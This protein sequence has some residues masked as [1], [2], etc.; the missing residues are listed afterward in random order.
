MRKFSKIFAVLLVACILVSAMLVAASAAI[1]TAAQMP[2]GATGTIKTATYKA[3]VGDCGNGRQGKKYECFTVNVNTNHLTS[4]A[5]NG[6]SH[7]GK[8]C[9][10]SGLLFSIAGGTSADGGTVFSANDIKNFNFKYLTIDF[11]IWSDKYIDANGGLTDDDTGKIAYAPQLKLSCYGNSP[12][13]K[14]NFSYAYFV[15]DGTYWYLSIDDSYDSSDVR[16]S[17]TVNVKNH[18]TVIDDGKNSYVF[19]DGEYVGTNNFTASGATTF[20]TGINVGGGDRSAAKNFSIATSYVT[21]NSYSK[22]YGS[23]TKFGIDD[24]FGKAD[25][26]MNLHT[27]EDAWYGDVEKYP[28]SNTATATVTYKDSNGEEIISGEYN[29]SKVL[30]KEISSDLDNGWYSSSKS[31]KIVGADAAATAGDIVAGGSYTLVPFENGYEADVKNFKFNVTLLDEFKYNVYI[32]KPNIDGLTVNTIAGAAPVDSTV[33][34]GYYSVESGYLT[35]NSIDSTFDVEINFTVNGEALSDEIS[36]SLKDY[37]EMGL[38]QYNG[39]ETETKLL[40]TFLDYMNSCV[41]Y[42][43]SQA[44]GWA[45]TIL[46][47]YASYLAAPNPTEAVEV[48]GIG[49]YMIS[50]FPMDL[51]GLS[52]VARAGLAI[53]VP[54]GESVSVSASLTGIADNKTNQTVNLSFTE[55][56]TAYAYSGVEYDVYVVNA[57]DLAVYN[58]LETMTVTIGETTTTFNLATYVTANPE[59]ELTNSLYRFAEAAKAFKIG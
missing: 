30:N 58:M 45:D 20:R 49:N 55:Y 41:T 2:A 35:F 50:Y 59:V 46:S 48:D 29:V 38:A 53:Y 14:A 54:T 16:F 4:G 52:G 28:N 21:V 33:L 37:I 42:S 5:H 3:K 23:G 8:A 9:P 31:W 15:T 6:T 51:E 47:S 11:D 40:V 27:C 25:F 44:P 10:T 18:I 22:D 17:N 7:E 56:K 1:S 19:L 13:T 43:G 12:T 57:T 34:D 36:V 39:K 24:Y 26:D 32:E